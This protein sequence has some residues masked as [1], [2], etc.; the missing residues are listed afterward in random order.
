MLAASLRRTNREVCF[1]KVSDLVGTP[2]LA[3]RLYNC[4]LGKMALIIHLRNPQD[5]YMAMLKGQH[6]VNY[7][8][9]SK[10]NIHFTILCSLSYL[11]ILDS[12]SQEVLNFSYFV[13]FLISL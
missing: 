10:F 13:I 2:K 12:L 5:W 8:A 3:F 1:H 4:E 11:N 9:D 6:H 7:S